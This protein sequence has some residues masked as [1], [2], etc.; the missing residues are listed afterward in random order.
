MPIG[1]HAYRN[2]F[3]T[4]HRRM[5]IVNRTEN[6]RGTLSILAGGLHLLKGIDRGCG[7]RV[8]RDSWSR[9]Y[10]PLG[11]HAFLCCCRAA[12]DE[13]SV[14]MNSNISTLQVWYAGACITTYDHVCIY[15]ADV[16][17]P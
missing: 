14:C 1:N 12:G 2:D 13:F 6:S 16:G 11:R 4:K 15:E 7:F 3:F 8:L 9:G 10:L 5:R 17:K